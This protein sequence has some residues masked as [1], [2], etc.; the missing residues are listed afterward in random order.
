MVTISL[1]RGLRYK[2]HGYNITDKRAYGRSGAQPTKKLG[3]L[4][5]APSFS[6]KHLLIGQARMKLL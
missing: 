1:S 2:P 3:P 5:Q 6:P 4:K